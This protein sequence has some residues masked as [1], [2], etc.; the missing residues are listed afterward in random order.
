MM[1]N[2]WRRL[3][4]AALALTVTGFIA[5]NAAQSARS[6]QNY[7]QID[8][9]RLKQYVD[10]YTAIS[11]TYRDQGHQ[12]WGRIIGT[13][14]DE[15]SRLWVA[16][17]FKKAGLENVRDQMFDLQPQWFPQSWRVTIKGRTELSLESVQPT[18][19]TAATPSGGL[20]TEAVYVGMG[21]DAELAGRDVRGKAVFIYSAPLP[22]MLHHTAATEGAL[23]RVEAKGAAAI[24]IILALPGNIRTQMYPQGTT[25]PTF[26]MGLED[27]MKV[28]AMIGEAAAGPAP[29]VVV[30]LDTKM[31]PN[32]R[33]STVWGELPGTTDEN[34]MIIG[35]RDGWFEG[36]VDNASGVA[37]MAGLADYFGKLP[38]AQ[39]RRTI[40]FLGTSGH[41]DT[42]VSGNEHPGAE[43][44]AWLAA[45]KELFAKTALII[46]CEHLTVT[47]TYVGDQELKK[48]NSTNP[49]FWYIGGSAK[50]SELAL[51]AFDRFGVSRYTDPDMAPPGEIG[52]L[53]Q[54]APSIQVIDIGML[55]HSDHETADMI[56]ASGLQAI[57]RAYAQIITESGSLALS[58]L[59]RESRITR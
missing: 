2:N 1:S 58:D 15:A 3:A 35:H 9:A 22:S 51:R 20:E 45:H 57:T 38:K 27:G 18:Y 4:G 56:P 29:R 8:G 42:R 11:K 6:E 14:G 40:T 39:R 37:V 32:L 50:L 44:T 17:R 26:S 24:F 49:L 55:N 33:T 59:N 13:E 36:S 25:V 43:S 34:V 10:E 48:T 16:D 5:V 31:V 47:Q 52:R 46:N 53:Y 7:A 30:R 54:L 19:L 28:R 41:H 12:F 21:S 23:K